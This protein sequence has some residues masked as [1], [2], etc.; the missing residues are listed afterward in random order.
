M[1]GFVFTLDATMAVITAI[2]LSAVVISI[3]NT[4]SA[5]SAQGSQLFALGN[6]MLTVL[7]KSGRLNS[8][9]GQ[10]ASSVNPELG[11]HL[12]MIPLQYCGNITVSSYSHS[13]GNFNLQDSF[14]NSTNNCPKKNDMYKARRMFA[15][16]GK[17]RFA[18]AEMEV[19]LK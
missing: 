6:D 17:Q 4:G 5:P 19:W 16:Y 15:D 14:T 9:L 1:K 18:L 2:I 11:Q 12:D 3:F 7:F 10:P 8:Y 13:G